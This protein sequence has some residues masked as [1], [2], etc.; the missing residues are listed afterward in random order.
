MPEPDKHLFLLDAEQ[1]RAAS[2]AGDFTLVCTCGLPQSND[3]HLN[4]LEGVDHLIERKEQEMA[5]IGKSLVVLYMQRMKLTFRAEHN[6]PTARYVGV[7]WNDVYDSG[8]VWAHASPGSV[9]D[10]E[11]SELSD[12]SEDPGGLYELC[13]AMLGLDMTDDSI[14]YVLDLEQGVFITEPHEIAKLGLSS[15]R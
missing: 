3:R 13:D 9:W 6:F 11:G 2:A 12:E 7:C 5:E 15:V 4:G 10:A 8:R 14:E 1:S